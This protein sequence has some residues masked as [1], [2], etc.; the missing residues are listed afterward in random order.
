MDV[1]E[2]LE[3]NIKHPHTGLVYSAL[4]VVSTYLSNS[5]ISRFVQMVNEA[6]ILQ[7]LEDEGVALQGKYRERDAR[8]FLNHSIQE[9]ERGNSRV[10]LIARGGTPAGCFAFKSCNDDAE[11][12]YWIGGKHRGLGTGML[13]AMLEV[14]PGLGYSQLQ[15]LTREDNIASRKILARNGFM[16]V[17]RF[18]RSGKNFRRHRWLDTSAPSK[19]EQDKGKFGGLSKIRE[20]SRHLQRIR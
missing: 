8:N 12:G 19:T 3:I 1:P 14:A 5:F 13:A 17:D 15:A 16:E 4:P 11:I 6:D 7:L 2:E 10:F 9:W 18:Q 20:L